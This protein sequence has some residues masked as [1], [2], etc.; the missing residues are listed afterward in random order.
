[1]SWDEISPFRCVR[2]RHGR[3]SHPAIVP[4]TVE[5]V[6]GREVPGHLLS[7]EQATTHHRRVRRRVDRL[8]GPVGAGKTTAMRALHALGTAAHEKD[9]LIG[10][11]PS[12]VAAQILAESLEVECD[13]TAPGLTAAFAVGPETAAD[14]L[15]VAGDDPHRIR[16]QPAFAKLCGV[17]PIPASSGMTT[18]R[19]LNRGGHRQANA[20]LYRVVIV[21]MQHHEPMKAHVVRSTAE[22]KT[23]SQ[24]ISCLKRLLA[25]ELWAAMR[26][27]RRVPPGDEVRTCCIAAASSP[28]GSCSEPNDRVSIWHIQTGMGCAWAG[29]RRSTA[30]RS[31]PPHYSMWTQLAL[32]RSPWRPWRAGW[33]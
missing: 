17:A 33:A 3:S 19:R 22:G 23:K 15:I 31:W 28:V 5:E 1:M 21:R 20:A 30:R 11:A 29:R 2:C 18:R 7:D 14:T 6:T 12:V 8:V 32:E 4:V 9:G 10:L 27:L 24:I 25:R 13:N 16:N 26:P